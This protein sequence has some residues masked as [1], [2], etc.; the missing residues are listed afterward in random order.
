MQK[1]FTIFLIL[2]GFSTASSQ[3][4]ISGS[5]IHDGLVRNYLLY[6]PSCYSPAQPTPLVFNLHGHG[7][8]NFEQEVYGDFRSIADTACFLIVLPNG[9]L[10]SNGVRYWNAGFDPDAVDDVGFLNA[11]IDSLSE[12]YNINPQRIYSTGMSNGGFM[13]YELACQSDR[14]AAIAS[15]TGSMFILSDFNCAPSRPIPVMQIHGTADV[16]VPY[17]GSSLTLSI[18]SLVKKWVVL[19][20]CP[21]TP[22]SENIPDLVPDDSATAI[23]YVYSPGDN[24]VSVELYKIING[25]HTWPG[26]LF[27]IGTTCMD[28][29]ASAEIW[30]FFSQY[31]LAAGISQKQEFVNAI[32]IQPNPVRDK[33]SLNSEKGNIESYQIY[34]INGAM[35]MEGAS[36]G[37]SVE[38]ST[39]K[40]MAGLYFVRIQSIEG[41]FHAKFIR[42]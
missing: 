37:N 13:S 7:S 36:D 31:S 32:S 22:I 17:T 26:S 28:F 11:L 42:Q 40:L 38:I 15:V 12:D 34:D 41:C 10:D 23:H 3:S 33:L 1:L 21:L 30:R 35:V 9:T 18:D 2:A 39:D 27:I 16:T 20:N 4:S 19:N 14:F 6:V 5:I 25:A 29:N 24:G 8:Q